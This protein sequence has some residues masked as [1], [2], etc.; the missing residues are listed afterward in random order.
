MTTEELV[1]PQRRRIFYGWWV[2]GVSVVCAFLGATTSQLFTG[3][4]L[5]D[6][7][8]DTGWSRSSITLGVTM[9]SMAAG[10]ASPLFGRLADRYGSRRLTFIGV[11]VT[12]TGMY[13]LAFSSTVHIIPFYVSY[14]VARAISQN[15]LSGVVPRTTAVNWF[16]R[17][18]GRAL[19]MI[20]MAIPLGGAALVPIG[21]LISSEYGWQTVY[22]VFGTVMLIVLLPPVLL[23]LRRRPEDMGLRPDGDEVPRPAIAVAGKTATAAASESY[24]WTLKQAMR[25]PAFWLLIGAITFGTGANGA[26]GF[27]QAAYFR[28]QGIAAAAVA[29]AISSYALAGAFA[30]G[31]WG[32]LVERVS[33]RLLGTVT[34][35]F[36]GLLPLYLL[37]VDTAAGALIFAVLFGLAARGESS[38]IVMIQAQYFGRG[39]FGAI[40]GFSTP[41]Q[42]VAL[43]LGPTV[44]ALIYEFF[45]KSYTVA[46]CLFGAMFAMA[47]T[48]VFLAR[49]PPLPV[50]AQSLSAD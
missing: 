7:E 30:N 35:L 15:T 1:A 9:G 50:E 12:A 11:I 27:H 36:A 19:G 10:F 21:K 45:D 13:L 44:A 8:Q 18:R 42:Q 24:D 2:L 26:V 16:R 6:I 48:M 22:Y 32:F 37:T 3:A 20:S 40:S 31:L 47:A 38:I 23:I 5:P 49:K 39:S 43:G 41:F 17:K 25:T 4:M 28:D 29:L 34:L 14:V 33:E 46:F